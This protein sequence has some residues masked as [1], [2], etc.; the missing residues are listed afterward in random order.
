MKTWHSASRRTLV[1]GL[2]WVSL[3]WATGCSR[4]FAVP[5]SAKTVDSGQLPFDRVS[6]GGGISPT[7]A[8]DPASVPVGTE[9]TVQ[10]RSP[11]SSADSRGEDTFETVLA[12]PVIVS[13]QTVVPQ[14]TPAIGKVVAAKAAGGRRDPGYLRLI[15]ASIVLNGR[16][17]PLQTSSVFAKG[18]THGKR[19]QPASADGSE[20]ENAAAGTAVDSSTGGEPSRDLNRGDVRFS[21][22]RRLTFH[23]A[24]PLRLPN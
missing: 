15:L 22:G 14:G 6:D 11:L 7:A 18:E 21:T 24:Q 4:Q 19:S 23:V 3:A 9:I 16:S 20:L 13:G 8:L 17:I 2:A 1:L 12:E 10:L 5:G